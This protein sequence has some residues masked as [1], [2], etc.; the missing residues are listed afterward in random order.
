[1]WGIASKPVPSRKRTA[2][3]FLWLLRSKLGCLSIADTWTS[4][5]LNHHSC[6]K[7]WHD[8]CLKIQQQ[9]I[10]NTKNTQMLSWYGKVSSSFWVFHSPHLTISSAALRDKLHIADVI[11]YYQLSSPGRK[12]W[13]QCKLPKL[14]T[15]YHQYSAQ[16][17]GQCRNQWEKPRTGRSSVDPSP[18]FEPLFKC[19]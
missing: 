11:R 5:Y 10:R 13:R 9:K 8:N 18:E 7:A 16:L 12:W 17:W 19:S 6:V 2:K 4:W 3:L 14:L 1:M 15:L